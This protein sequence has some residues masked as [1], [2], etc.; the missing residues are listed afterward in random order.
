MNKNWFSVHC[1]YTLRVTFCEYG[2]KKKPD[3][4]AML[5]VENCSLTLN[6]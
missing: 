4:I 2:K 6:T 1:I 3:S 5:L